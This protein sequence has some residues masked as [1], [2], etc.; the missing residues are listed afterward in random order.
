MSVDALPTAEERDWL[1]EQ[2]AALMAAAGWQRLVNAP[3]IEPADRFFPDRWTP[4]AAGVRRMGLR[5]LRFAG[6]GHLDVAVE[7]FEGERTGE[8]DGRSRSERHEGA[9]AW[10]AGIVDDVVQFGSASHGLADPAGLTGT[11]SHEVAHVFRRV[12]GLEVED[13]DLEERLTDLTTIWLGFGVLTTNATLKHRSHGGFDGQNFYNAYSRQS[14]GYLPP[15]AMAFLLALQ[16]CARNLAPAD[17]RYV[18]GLLETNQGAWFNKACRWISKEV[19]DLQAR[20]GL[21]DPSTWPEAEDVAPMLGPLAHADP[22]ERPAPVRAVKRSPNRGRPVFRVLRTRALAYGGPMLGL[23]CV[24]IPFAA[25]SSG[26]P[27]MAL[28]VGGLV[29]VIAGISIGRRVPYDFCSDPDCKTILVRDATECPGCKGVV[30][31]TIRHPDERLAALEEHRDRERMA[32]LQ[33]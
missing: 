32:R 18:A 28:V 16:A 23:M 10:F 1:I 4:D 19:P 13:R 2:L 11:M 20:L 15:Q 25:V 7:L 21:P 9:A 24:V 22:T 30:V 27:V 8:S 14:V 12:H 33:S 5:L 3:L 31:G 29:V 17:L 26:L 6:L